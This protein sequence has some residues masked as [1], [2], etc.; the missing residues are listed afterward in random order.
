MHPLLQTDADGVNVK[1]LKTNRVSSVED[2]AG[3]AQRCVNILAF[4]LRGRR[5]VH[6]PFTPPAPRHWSGPLMGC[7]S[8]PFVLCLSGDWN[9]RWRRHIRI[10]QHIVS[11]SPRASFCLLFRLTGGR[12][13]G[14]FK[15]P[16]VRPSVRLFPPESI[17]PLTPHV[18]FKTLLLMSH[19]VLRRCRGLFYSPP[20]A[21]QPKIP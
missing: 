6:R 12:V 16:C 7:K 10:R 19:Y 9:E 20:L 14:T 2:A 8:T 13:C 3:A 17:I 11:G 21:K 5:R 4:C 15:R 18:I 1:V